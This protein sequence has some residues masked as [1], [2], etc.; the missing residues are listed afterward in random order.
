MAFAHPHMTPTYLKY[1]SNLPMKERHMK[2][3]STR[4]RKLQSL[5]AREEHKWRYD[6]VREYVLQRISNSA[7]KDKVHDVAAEKLIDSVVDSI[8]EDQSFVFKVRTRG[9]TFSPIIRGPLLSSRG[10]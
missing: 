7:Q 4:T 3:S 8:V 9:A 6:R 1:S 2:L 10:A 5:A